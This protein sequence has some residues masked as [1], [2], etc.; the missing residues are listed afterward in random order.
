MKD[1]LQSK[2]NNLIEKNHETL[3]EYFDDKLFHFVSLTNL[4]NE[5]L[6]C[7]LLELNQAS[8]FTTNHFLERMIKLALIEKHTLNLNYS[9]AELY[10]EKTVE[11]IKLYDN[12][13][14]FES[15]KLAKEED[16]ITEAE[17]KILND[18]RSKIRNPYSHAEIKKI[19]NEAPKNF[20]GFMFNLNEV[21]ESLSKGEPI[22]MGE[23]KVITTYSSAIS[24]L[25]Q[26]NLSQQIALNYFKTVYK[27]LKN[28]EER[29]EKMKTNK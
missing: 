11:A 8:I 13:V 23:K 17:Q 21:K 5:T 22:K 24:Q 2:S 15:L 16:L 1:Y 6:Q 25:Y 12:L 20:T 28:I 19:L 29:I 10:N 14:L 7:L 26:E 27:I 9:N 3:K 4:R 18:F